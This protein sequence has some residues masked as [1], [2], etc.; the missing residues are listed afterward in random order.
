MTR[1]LHPYPDVHWHKINDQLGPVHTKSPVTLTSGCHIF[2][3]GLVRT[4]L[5]LLTVTAKNHL[6]QKPCFKAGKYKYSINSSITNIFIFGRAH[7]GFWYL[8]YRLSN[9]MVCMHYSRSITLKKLYQ[10]L[11]VSVFVCYKDIQMKF[12][13]VPLAELLEYYY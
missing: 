5:S 4:F 1:S 7:E 6:L 3:S 9:I 8:R 2:T 11:N 10:Y 12:V 13:S